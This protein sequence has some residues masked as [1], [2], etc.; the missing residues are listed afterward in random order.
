MIGLLKLILWTT[1]AAVVSA[2]AYIWAVFRSVSAINGEHMQT[3]TVVPSSLI[4]STTVRRLVN[5]RGHMMVFC[6]FAYTFELRGPQVIVSDEAVLAR[7]VRGFFFGPVLAVE[8]TFIKMFVPALTRFKDAPGFAD[9]HNVWS[10]SSLAPDH[11]PPKNTILFGCFYVAEVSLGFRHEGTYID[12]AFGS[13]AGPAASLYRFSVKRTGMHGNMYSE[14][15][16][17]VVTVHLSSLSCNPVV[18]RPIM[19]QWFQV[20]QQMYVQLLFRDGMAE[21]INLTGKVW[22]RIPGRDTPP[23]WVL[24]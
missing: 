17:E 18:N 3:S 16:R 9:R 15:N 6:S 12:F 1:A 19:P 24:H 13:D 5:P 22:P 20:Y 4:R 7:F 8:R 21:V 11:L 10:S 2:T 23:L 14:T